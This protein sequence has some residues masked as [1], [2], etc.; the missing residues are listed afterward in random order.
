MTEE[1]IEQLV[2]G[3]AT[4]TRTSRPV[5]WRALGGCEACGDPAHLVLYRRALC[6]DCARNE[7]QDG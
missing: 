6:R 1:R 3:L 7:L 5:R 2:E 4:M